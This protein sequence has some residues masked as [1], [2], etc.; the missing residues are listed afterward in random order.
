M[1]KA[2]ISPESLYALCDTPTPQKETVPNYSPVPKVP[3][4]KRIGGFFKKVVSMVRPALYALNVCATV[5]NAV[6]KFQST[7]HRNLAGAS[8]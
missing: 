8:I 6:S 5:L 1:K 2:I 7:S 3:F 4:W